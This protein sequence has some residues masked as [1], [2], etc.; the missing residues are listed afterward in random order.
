MS[1]IKVNEIG[2]YFT[3][4]IEIWFMDMKQVKG[5]CRESATRKVPHSLVLGP[6]NQYLDQG[7]GPTTYINVLLKSN[8]FL[9]LNTI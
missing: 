9:S 4:G 2:G 3:A 5:S 8:V 7:L 6:Q 1:K